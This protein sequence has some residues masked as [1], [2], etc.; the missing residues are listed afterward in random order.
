VEEFVTDA[1]T[2]IVLGLVEGITEYLPISSTGHL[3][4]FGEALQFTGEK[5]KSFD[6]V[7]QLGAILSVLVLFRERFLGLFGDV[8]ETLRNPG[9]VRAP[10]M[11]G[12]AGIY[13]LCVVSVPALAVG[14]L[15]RHQIKEHLFAPLPV[16]IALAVGALLILLVEH[17]GVANQR[18]ELEE[19]SWKQSVVIGV[20]QCLALWPGMSRSASTIIGGMLVGLS[21][22]A[23]AEFSFLAAVPVLGAA[24]L[25]DLVEV[26]RVFSPEDLK[27][28]A[29]GFVIS[30]ISALITMKWFMRLVSTWSLKPFAYYRLCLAALVIFLL[31]MLEAPGN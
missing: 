19:L 15:L 7:I 13:K 14:F 25:H 31:S 21:R 24:A 8:R 6:I 16:A 3:I 11:Y 23:A 10:G 17:S 12:A 9:L 29:I 30:F 2:A 18:Q 1:L 26:V 5:A 28:V 27:L 20:V 22:R 4:L